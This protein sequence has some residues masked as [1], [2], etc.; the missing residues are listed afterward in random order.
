[1]T[2]PIRQSHFISG[3]LIALHDYKTIYFAIP[4]VAN[5]SMK[6][7]CAD[8][9]RPRLSA[10]FLDQYWS[11]KWKPRIFRQ[12]EARRYLARKR[13]LLS[14]EQ[15][16]DYDQYWRFCLVRNPWDRL[17]SCWKQKIDGATGNVSESLADDE[18]FRA[19]MSFSEFAAVVAE[20]PDEKA[21]G[22]FRSQHTFIA[23]ETGETAVHY[24]GKME[25]LDQAMEYVCEK[26]NIPMQD[27]PH[28]LKRDGKPYSEYYTSATRE[29]ISARYSRDIALLGYSFQ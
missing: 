18:R 20:T 8:L 21:N 23:D 17:V 28:L 1:M 13:I 29:L 27:V 16:A 12:A 15:L 9:V 2:T 4:K 26:T 5:S 6:A 19:G 11:E 24:V 14:R 3:D 25:N 7:L 22:H 10:E